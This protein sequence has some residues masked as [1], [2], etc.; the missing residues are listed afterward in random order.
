MTEEGTIISRPR[1]GYVVVVDHEGRRVN[2]SKTLLEDHPGTVLFQLTASAYWEWRQVEIGEEQLAGDFEIRVS[3]VEHFT[4]DRM[5]AQV[6]VPN[7]RLD[8]AIEHATGADELEARLG[9]A[10]ADRMIDA[11][12]KMGGAGYE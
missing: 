10:L 11:R 1:E 3:A 9:A 7:R 12:R 5:V 4:R 8:E 6:S 2:V